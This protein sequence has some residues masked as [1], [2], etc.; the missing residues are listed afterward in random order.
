MSGKWEE[1][2]MYPI[3]GKTNEMGYRI[4]QYGEYEVEAVI[5]AAYLEMLVSIPG[6]GEFFSRGFDTAVRGSSD[7]TSPQTPF[8]LSA[9]QNPDNIKLNLII[10]GAGKVWIDDV[11]VVKPPR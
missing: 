10:T 3:Y 11:S 8:F 9:G 7:W 2:S 1:G 5:G 4:Y 6:R